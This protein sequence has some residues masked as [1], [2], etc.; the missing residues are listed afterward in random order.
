MSNTEKN[1]LGK[2]TGEFSTNQIS[3]Y[4]MLIVGIACLGGGIYF[5]VKA[6]LTREP[7]ILIPVSV[8]CFGV[9]VI[10]ALALRKFWKTRGGRIELYENGLVTDLGGRHH[11][12]A[13]SEIAAVK[14][15]I[16]A[17]YV[18]GVHTSDRYAYTIEKTNGEFFSFDNNIFQTKRI[19]QEIKDKTFD[20]MYPAALQKIKLGGS[21][22]FGSL[23]V[24]S[25]GLSENSK[26]FIWSNLGAFNV[27]DGII[28]ITDRDGKIVLEENYAATP[29]AHV[30]VAL[31]SEFITPER[32]D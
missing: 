13:W 18:N 3:R 30:L 7:V 31:L 12:T 1:H 21:A 27:K 11:V 15:L 19:G 6:F 8:I 9:C 25:N 29:N 20:L 26:R 14:E 32:N 10:G 22:S 16:Q 28:E 23:L 17:Y 2:L 24:D 4:I 5:A